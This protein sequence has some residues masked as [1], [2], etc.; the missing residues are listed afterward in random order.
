MRIVSNDFLAQ[1]QSTLDLLFVIIVILLVLSV[2]LF[3]Y[4]VA[5]AGKNN[6]LEEEVEK[7]Q[8]RINRL[9]QQN[10]TTYK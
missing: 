9:N 1:T 3:G 5:V 6:D 2:A 7:L 4:A 10:K 8:R